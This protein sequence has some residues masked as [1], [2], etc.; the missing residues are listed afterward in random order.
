[1]FEWAAGHTVP[2]G[3]KTAV[4]VLF[5][6]LPLFVSIIFRGGGNVLLIYHS[7]VLTIWSRSDIPHLAPPRTPSSSYSPSPPAPHSGFAWF[8]FFLV[9]L[10]YHLSLCFC[11]GSSL[12][13]LSPLLCFTL[14]SCKIC[15]CFSFLFF[16]LT[17]TS[18]HLKFR[19]H[20]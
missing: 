12:H 3:S 4:V 20:I 15:L 8:N 5:F 7:S 10:L 17:L 14:S 18:T 2:G 6:C 16:F 1:M 19:C 11:V 13:P 9:L